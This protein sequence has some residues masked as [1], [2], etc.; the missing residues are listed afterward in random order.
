MGGL[1]RLRAVCLQMLSQRLA[2]G[3][4]RIL[5][6]PV[7]QPLAFAKV[8]RHLLR[9]SSTACELVPVAWITS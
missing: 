8:H 3:Y 4:G 9:I 5:N 1:G 6:L 7:K 2:D